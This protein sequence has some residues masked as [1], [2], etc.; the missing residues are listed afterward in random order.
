MNREYDEKIGRALRA[1]V[2]HLDGIFANIAAMMQ[3]EASTI[4][5]NFSQVEINRHGAKF[6]I[7]R[8]RDGGCIAEIRLARTQ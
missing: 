2:E 1:E 8:H 7:A 5:L 4:P 3:L 6:T